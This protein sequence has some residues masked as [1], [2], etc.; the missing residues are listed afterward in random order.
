MAAS[1]NPI[2]G[3]LFAEKEPSVISKNEQDE[4]RD[5]SN[6]N[7]SNHQLKNDALA[8]P[9]VQRGSQKSNQIIDPNT[10]SNSEI[11][12]PKWSHHDLSLIHI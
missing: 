9:R 10:F 12:D 5:I 7:L 2:Q 6:E 11:E 3:S 4:T 8:R 1:P